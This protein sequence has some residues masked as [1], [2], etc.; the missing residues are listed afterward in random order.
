MQEILIR[1]GLTIVLSL[2]FG[3][4]RQR[5]HKP[6]GLGIFTLVASGA[7]ALSLLAQQ[8]APETPLAAMGP[9]VTGIGF[10]GAGALI[11]T[12]DKIFGFTTAASIW[13]FGIFGL[14]IGAGNYLIGSIIY[15]VIWIIVLLD[16]YL[17]K[18]GI[19]SYQKRIIIH[20][21]KIIP[22]KDIKQLINTCTTRSKLI[23]IEVN[24]KENTLALSY[25]VEGLRD[26][27]NKVPQKLFEKEWL[28]DCKIE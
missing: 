8:L 20:T 13:L 6:A 2:I 19:G 4:E 17:E 12:S 3:L 28:S 10:L 16:R 26:D 11:K 24:K 22:E 25:L 14:V 9:V 7:C 27:L 21:T 15:G 5:A 18:Q 23:N 1:L